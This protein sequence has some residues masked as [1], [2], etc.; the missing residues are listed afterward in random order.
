VISPAAKHDLA[1]AAPIAHIYAVSTV[2]MLMYDAELAAWLAVA[3]SV[4]GPFALGLYVFSERST[5]SRVLLALWAPAGQ[6]AALLAMWYAVWRNAADLPSW[7][8]ALA[9]FGPI[10][11]LLAASV[12]FWRELRGASGRVGLVVLWAIA[13]AEAAAALPLA[14]WLATTAG[15]DMLAAVVVLFAPAAALGTWVGLVVAAMLPEPVDDEHTA[16][17]V[18]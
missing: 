14:E 16:E 4:V 5:L 2:L 8:L 18:A 11:A 7:A 12:P 9:T 17:A 3:A 1:L 15:V 6:W 10:V 13:L